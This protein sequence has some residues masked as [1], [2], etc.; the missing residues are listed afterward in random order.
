MKDLLPFVTNEVGF[1]IAA[2]LGNESDPETWK[3]EFRRI[4]KLNPGV[5]QF[6][7]GWSRHSK[8]K[9]HTAILGMIVYRLLE[10]QA[11]ADRMYEEYKV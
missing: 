4:K 3:R 11:E 9:L 7:A 1:S 6:I 10:S 2:S 5:A 8:D